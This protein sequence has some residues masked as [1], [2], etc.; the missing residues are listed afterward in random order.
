MSLMDAFL[1]GATGAGLFAKLRW[2]G[3]PMEL[4]DSRSPE[5]SDAASCASA[6]A[7]RYGAQSTRMYAKR[8]EQE[9]RVQ[10]ALDDLHLDAK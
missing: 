4:I 10:Q 3:A 9:V 2:P 1:D 7:K 6:L 5:Q 8:S